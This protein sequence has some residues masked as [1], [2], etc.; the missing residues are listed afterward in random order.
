MIAAIWGAVVAIVGAVVWISAL[1]FKVGQ[2]AG[3]LDE[4]LARFE[5]AADKLDKTNERLEAI[6]LI[7][8]QVE[9]LA[10]AFT[11]DRRRFNS[12]FPSVMAK[13]EQV[14]VLTSKV[15]ALM[16]KVFSID[17]WRKSQPKIGNGN[18]HGE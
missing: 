18:G 9:Q 12:V 3:G 13:A 10:F 11:E 2:K 7:K 14:P 1:L 8:Q 6:P 16:A 17:G 5:K 4:K 15:D